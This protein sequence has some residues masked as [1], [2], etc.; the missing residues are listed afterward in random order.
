MGCLE[1][2]TSMIVK[3]EVYGV[4]EESGGVKIP[5]RF[6]N[7]NDYWDSFYPNFMD[8]V[9]GYVKSSLRRNNLSK[10]IQVEYIKNYGAEHQFKVLEM[11]DPSEFPSRSLYLIVPGHHWNL[12][13]S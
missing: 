10:C 9:K 8:E 2:L 7:A 3:M 4:P 1:D 6:K 5:K 13:K 12:P 11:I